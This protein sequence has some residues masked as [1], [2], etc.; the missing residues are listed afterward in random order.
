M[1]N[2][3][4]LRK[5]Y[6]GCFMSLMKGLSLA[7]LFTMLFSAMLSAQQKRDR[8]EIAL[9]AGAGWKGGEQRFFEKKNFSYGLGFTYHLS[10]RFGIEADFSY[11]P[12][13]VD[14][15]LTELATS[16]L[17]YYQVAQVDNYRLLFD[18]NGLIHI[19]EIPWVKPFIILGFGWLHD[20]NH[21]VAYHYYRSPVFDQPYLS[22]EDKQDIIYRKNDLQFP[23]VG[24]GLNYFIKKDAFL[25]LKF[26]FHNPGGKEIQTTRLVVGFGFRF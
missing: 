25:R 11:L 13:S 17:I 6:R 22:L 18:I 23:N 16:P 1:I 12:F 4:P 19:V 7:V 9:Y 26:V 10:K 20:F 15:D 8:F 24:V 2:H 3:Y 21:M 5:H 14:L